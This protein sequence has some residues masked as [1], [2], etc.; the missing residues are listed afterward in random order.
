MRRFQYLLPLLGLSTLQAAPPGPAKAQVSLSADYAGKTATGFNAGDRDVSQ[1]ITR[2]EAVWF[3]EAKS[4]LHLR[5]GG[6]WQRTSWDAEQG[7]I[8]PGK[9]QNALAILGMDHRLTPEWGWRV[10]LRPGLYGEFSDIHGDTFNVPVILGTS[11][12]LSPK[13]LVLGGAGIN[14]WSRAK[15]FPFLGFMYFPNRQWS[16]E[17]VAPKPGV[18]F[19]PNERV[20]VRVG[21]ELEGGLYR[22]SRDFGDRHGDSR[23]NNDILD[24]RDVR[25]GGGVEVDLGKGIS[26]QLDGGHVIQR[27]F[28]YLETNIKHT[29]RGHAYGSASLKY[30]I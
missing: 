11:Y 12:R 18:R 10:E 8:L 7:A 25:A 16:V 26:L 28:R 2:T 6:A 13:W 30:R 29:S 17:L 19:R 15:A 23:L 3:P 27:T 22:L 1:L 20:N 4:N 14:V 5:I 24:V 9:V 21:F